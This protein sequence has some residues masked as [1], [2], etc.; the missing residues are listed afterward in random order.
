M[1]E[2]LLSAHRNALVTSATLDGCEL[3]TLN[4]DGRW[5]PM[6]RVGMRQLDTVNHGFASEDNARFV[7]FLSLATHLAESGMAVPCFDDFDWRHE[8]DSAKWLNA[9]ATA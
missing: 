2:P 3:A 5:Y 7:A 9:R 6:I 8:P 4:L 1:P